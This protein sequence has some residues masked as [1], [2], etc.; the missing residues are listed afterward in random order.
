MSKFTSAVVFGVGA[1]VSPAAVA[2]AQMGGLGEA[3]K[4]GF[5][6]GVLGTPVMS[7]AA[8]TS[9][10]VASLSPVVSPSPVASPSPTL[11]ASPA[12]PTATAS[13]VTAEGAAGML[14]ERAGQKAA[15]EAGKKMAP[16]LP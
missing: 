3:A 11:A 2:L 13:P 16:K 10:A 12:S 8:A 5:V 1:A 15:E 14:M 6:E 7:P 9:P 4:K